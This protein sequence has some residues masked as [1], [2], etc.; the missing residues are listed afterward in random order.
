M[1]MQMMCIRSMFRE[2]QKEERR[3][4]QGAAAYTYIPVPTAEAGVSAWPSLVGV[5]FGAESAWPSL[6]GLC[7]EYGAQAEMLSHRGCSQSS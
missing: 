3:A 2:E 6:V 7:T 4:H 1:I 5:C